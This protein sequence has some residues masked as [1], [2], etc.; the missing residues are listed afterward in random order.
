MFTLKF[1]IFVLLI[2]LSLCEDDCTSPP[3][4][5]FQQHGKPPLYLAESKILTDFLGN[6]LMF[7]EILRL[8]Q[9]IDICFARKSFD[10][11]LKNQLL[12]LYFHTR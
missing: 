10:Y 6:H 3:S 5:G 1:S 4:A 7:D 2:G 11:E 9:H 12:I 8:R